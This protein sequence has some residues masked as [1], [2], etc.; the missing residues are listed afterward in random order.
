MKNPTWLIHG[1]TRGIGLS[2]VREALARGVDVLAAC[3]TATPEL[4]ETGARVIEGVDL[5]APDAAEAL[6]R[7][8]DRCEVPQLDAVVLNAGIYPDEGSLAALDVD[9]LRHGFEVNALGQL[10]LVSAL[11][12]RLGTGS[13]IGLIT[14]RMGSIADNTSG[15]SYAYRMSKAA[16][17]MLGRSLSVDLA[18]RGVS[19]AIIHPG[20]VRTDMTSQRGL[21]DADTSAAGILD[22]M[23]QLGLGNT[24]TFWHQNGDV[25]PW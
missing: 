4:V 25:L 15:G 3:R 8:L 23:D 16:L 17:N 6:T 24:G 20:F 18:P 10:L 22:R 11:L 5:G 7:G 12:P 19:V 14:S 1:T 9:A 13:R 2:L 21:I